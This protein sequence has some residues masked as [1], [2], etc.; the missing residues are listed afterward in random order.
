MTGQGGKAR[1]AKHGLGA[2][3]VKEPYHVAEV[4]SLQTKTYLGGQGVRENLG[5]LVTSASTPQP[6]SSRFKPLYMTNWMLRA[7]RG[8][9][10]SRNLLPGKTFS[11]A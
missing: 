2:A 1:K 3:L 5:G 11:A 7:V 6:P 9:Q 10:S 8:S 4:P